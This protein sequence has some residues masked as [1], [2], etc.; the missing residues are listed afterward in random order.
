MATITD[1]AREAQVSEATVSRVLSGK[2]SVSPT[3]AARV[4]AAASAL[5]Y[6]PSATAQG[7]VR[8]RTGTVGVL[9]PD[10]ANPY[11][12]TLLEGIQSA[13]EK[14]GVWVVVAHSHED[15]ELE[16]ER[17]L[18][19]G[20]RS[21]GLIVCSPRMSEDSMRDLVRYLPNVVCTH[22]SPRGFATP[23]VQ[24]DVRRGSADLLALLRDTG[25]R[26]AVYLAGP[27]RA[28]SNAERLRSLADVDGLDVTVVECGSTMEDG[29]AVIE[30][31]VIDGATA[32]VAFNDLVA[33]GVLNRL[34]ELGLSVPE[35][36]AVT[37]FDDIAFARFSSPSL[38]TVRTPTREMGR[39]AWHL[40]SLLLDGRPVGRPRVLRTELIVRQSTLGR[41]TASGARRSGGRA[42]SGRSG[43]SGTSLRWV[44][45]RG[46]SPG[47]PG[48]SPPPDGAAG[49]PSSPTSSP[50]GSPTS[51]P[52][53]S[54]TSS[55]SRSPTSSPSPS[56]TTP[57]RPCRRGARRRP[58]CGRTLVSGGHAH[59]AG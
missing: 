4:V 50:K 16:L 51:S 6:R 47:R 58:G 27:A 33:F 56:P 24:S 46:W 18:E 43:R 36:V 10:L 49:A 9:V 19:L 31:D 37:G 22:R 12:H 7:L 32:V 14:D 20:R 21:D 5:G 42:R 52:S 53:R 3:L 44:S 48:L 30:P 23:V 59:R 15:P 26:R 55:P 38:T 54:P 41:S 8:G 25:H 2:G 17:A 40:M 29:Y 11:F 57:P 1:V 34:S 13:A 28:W 35:D 39:E 45:R